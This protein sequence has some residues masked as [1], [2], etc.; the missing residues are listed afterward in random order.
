MFNKKVLC[1]GNNG[2]NT[3]IKTLDLAINDQTTN[4]GLVVDPIFIPDLPGYYHTSIIDINTGG[5][6]QLAK[7][8][9][10]I[11]LLDQPV[12]Q[13]THWKPLLSTYKIMVEL[14]KL[15]YNTVYKDNDNIQKYKLFDNLTTENKKN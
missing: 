10:T 9:D 4:H 13:W 8:F 14:D 5:I 1:L 6:I 11:I 3:D 7:N 12:D 15:G 2:S